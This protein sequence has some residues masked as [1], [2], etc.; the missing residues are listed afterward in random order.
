MTSG[1]LADDRRGGEERGE[2]GDSAVRPPA[3]AGHGPGPGSGP[4]VEALYRALGVLLLAIP[5]VPLR[6]LFG[7]LEGAGALVPPGEWALGL[8]IFGVV[9]WL[10][11]MFGGA[12]VPSGR[13]VAA[14]LERGES[15]VWRGGLSV[16]LAAA[17]VAASLVAFHRTPHLIDS[18]VQLFQ[19]KIFAAG[20]LGAPRP[21]GGGFF[22]TQHMIVDDAG[23]YSQY[24]PGHPAL[25]AVGTAAGAAWL[26][27][28]ALSL[29]TGLSL[30]GVAE[31]L[32]GA[33]VGRFT[34]LLA[35]LSPF[36]WFMGASFMSHVSALFFVSVFLYLY[37]RWDESGARPWALAAGAAL[38]AAALSRPLTAVAV[39]VPFTGFALASGMSR[40]RGIVGALR[41][42]LLAGVG[43][44][45]TAWLYLAY[46]GQV[47]GDPFL[48]GYLKLR[49]EGHGLGFHATPWG[50][51]HTALAGLSNELVDLSLLNL[52]L[53]EGPVP[54][55]L[56]VG[57]TFALGWT[58]DRWDRRLLLAFLAVPAAYFFYWHRDAFLGPR[59]L[60]AGLAFLLPLT[61]RS[62]LEVLERLRGVRFRPGG[63]FRPVAADRWALVFVGLC[64][65]YGVLYGIPQRFRV[66]A[67]G[68]SSM[69]LDL[70]AE[71]RQAGLDRGLIFVKVSWGNRLL[72]RLRALGVPA[73][74]AEKVYRGVGHCRLHGLV[75]RAESE[76]WSGSR[77]GEALS[78][79]LDR[80][81]E[82]EATARIN[83]DP[84]LRLEDGVRGLTEDCR[85]EIRYDRRGYTI[86]SPH[87]LA[88]TPDLSGPLVVA[89]DLRAA[90]G[91][92][93]E[94]FPRRRAYLFDGEELRV[95]RPPTG[96]ADIGRRR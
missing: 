53:F 72:A 29:G 44:A 18:V 38:G 6:R 41:P 13:S 40:G 32:W 36:F 22:V 77:V 76:G 42:V 59:F 71:A 70:R 75:G 83:G 82:P 87:L 92:L 4:T 19:A 31:R 85:E 14:W 66:Y 48:P 61:A 96:A 49:G 17:L 1:T 47:T 69:K 89:R 78:R 24:A 63:L 88:N 33:T 84:T 58:T 30:H 64:F 93:T 79:A 28:V 94:R 3:S 8:A 12:R 21:P 15:G 25:L 56:P 26:V 20:D 10:V 60:Y 23:W 80:A 51:E 45:A 54:A 81:E 73:P 9:A 55:L 68:M 2:G 7:P 57:V 90:N 67:T 39:A 74:T 16:V 65:G 62:I 35:V 34:L 52:F 37:V 5:F 86:F 11:A 27:P 91:A 43:F 50:G 46:N 95:L